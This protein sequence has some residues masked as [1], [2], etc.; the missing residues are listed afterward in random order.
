MAIIYCE[1]TKSYLGYKAGAKMF[2]DEDEKYF[3]IISELGDENYGFTLSTSL[4]P[5][6]K[7]L[8][9]I[10]VDFKGTNIAKHKFNTYYGLI[11]N[12]IKIPV[13]FEL[14]NIED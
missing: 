8:K 11:C 6:Y 1:L 7:I 10:V 13:T 5:E 14:F 9:T 12:R 4:F 3:S 2:L